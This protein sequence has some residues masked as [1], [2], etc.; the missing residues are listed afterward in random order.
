VSKILT[1]KF[2]NREALNVAKDLLGCYLVHKIKGKEIRARII[3][4]EAYIGEDDLACHASK[5]RTP[6]S[7]TLYGEGGRAYVYLIYGM[8]HIF[9]VVAEKKRFSCGDH[10]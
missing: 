5:G 9:N 3:D 7:E 2:Y 6:R 4:V 1:K 8:Y 10:D